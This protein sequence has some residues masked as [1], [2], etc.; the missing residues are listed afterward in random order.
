MK[1]WVGFGSEHSANL[2]MIG[3]FDTSEK[4]ESA[5]RQLEELCALVAENFD[6][7]RFQENPMAWYLD[8]KLMERLRKLGLYNFSPEDIESLSADHTIRRVGTEL[9][10]S[11][12]ESTVGGLLKF[13]ID[14]PAR[15]EVYSAHHFPDEDLPR[16]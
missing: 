7:E 5:T 10:I 15:V 9:R 8:E 14:S 3:R 13:M 12:D 11:T 4:A 2:R 16:P 1:V 6:Y